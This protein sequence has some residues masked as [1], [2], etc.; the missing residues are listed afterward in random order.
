M[1]WTEERLKK[2]AE[3]N[4]ETKIHRYFAIKKLVEEIV[5]EETHCQ[6]SVENG[7]ATCG[8]K[9]DCHLHDWRA[10]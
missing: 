8:V 10:K 9:L 3:V 5:E 6:K 2:L 7:K 1:K 4:K